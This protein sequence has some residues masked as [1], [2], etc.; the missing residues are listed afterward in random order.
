MSLLNECSLIKRAGV[1]EVISL[2]SESGP[3]KLGFRNTSKLYFVGGASWGEAA[4]V[5]I[6]LLRLPFNILVPC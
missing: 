2:C 6:Y 3:P 4:A 1:Q 5:L